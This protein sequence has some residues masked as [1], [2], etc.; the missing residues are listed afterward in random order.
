MKYL[1]FDVETTGLPKR[2]FA[3]LYKSELW[4][5]IVQ[6]S[7]V[8]YDDETCRIVSVNDHIIKLPTGVKLPQESIRIHGI[9]KQIMFKKGIHIKKALK[10]FE[11]DFNQCD[12]LVAHNITFDMNII[13][14]EFLRNARKGDLFPNIFD[15]SPNKKKL[16]TMELG[17]NI[18]KIIRKG[19]NG[20][21]Y[22]K[23]PKLIELHEKLFKQTINN[24][25]NSLVDVYACLRC[26][27]K[28][29]LN[30]DILQKDTSGN[31]IDYYTDISGM[32]FC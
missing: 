7:W 18:C 5:Y 25:H 9:T 10:M 26:F 30:Y 1:V 24:A 13:G 28:I 17:K 12:S 23:S 19:K 14:A 11:T 32:S 15:M 27:C 20:E 2:R 6:I 4:P 31:F 8:V 3:P 29:Y 22:Y 16:C 21:P